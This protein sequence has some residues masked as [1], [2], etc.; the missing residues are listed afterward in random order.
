M[1]VADCPAFHQS[2]NECELLRSYFNKGYT[3]KDIKD[4]M[5]T[6]HGIFLSEDQLR[7]KLKALG[8]KRRRDSV[9]SPLDE[10]EAAIQ[11]F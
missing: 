3:Y 2:L 10:V 1:A 11:V 9:E 7:R 8:L 6:K 5:E 4:F